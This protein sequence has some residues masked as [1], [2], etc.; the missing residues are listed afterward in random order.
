PTPTETPTP[1]PI[2]TDL[3]GLID[4]CE[5]TD[6]ALLTLDGL[7]TWTN[8]LLPDSDG[9]GLLDGQ[10]EPQFAGGPECESYLPILALT[11][12]RKFDSD[13]DGFSDGMEVLVMGTDPL[14]P[15]DPDPNDP[16]Y[17]DAD[18]DGLPAGIDPDDTNPDSD[19]DGYSDGYE[20]QQGNNPNDSGDYPPLGDVNCD[21]V[22][23]NLDVLLL[24][25]Y[26]LG[27]ISDPG[28]LKN[29]DLNFD[30]I[31]NNL[32]VVILYNW[33]LGYLPLLPFLP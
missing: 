22:P 12:P 9:D 18:G 13:G 29:T 16:N 20:V 31:T 5:T 10:E 3:D 1:T 11:D 6:P 4:D 23:N 26:L 17:A 28:C 32:D 21:G 14:D 19:G 25:H 24:L 15:N 8:T 27:N 30:G 7:T 33:I 2:D